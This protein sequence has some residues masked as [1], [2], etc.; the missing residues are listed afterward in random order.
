MVSCKADSGI[1]RAKP[2]VRAD[3]ASVREL[4]DMRRA[5]KTLGFLSVA[6]LL[7]TLGALVGRT[8]RS[9]ANWSL[10]RPDPPPTRPTRM[11][12]GMAPDKALADA[13]SALAAAKIELFDSYKIHMQQLDNKSG[14]G[15][16]FVALPETPDMDVYV[17]VKS[18]GSSSILMAP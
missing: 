6:I 13:L 3:T 18:D 12:K 10:A 4:T 15:V 11:A 9:K 8:E 16:W 5:F 14:W 17:T 2:I 7:L 1:V